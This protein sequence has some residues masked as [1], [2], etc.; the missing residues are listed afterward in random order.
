MG[1]LEFRGARLDVRLGCSDAERAR[2][3]AVD[4]DVAVRFAELPRACE[5]DDLSHTV[6]YADLIDAARAACAGREFKLVERLAH[7]LHARLRPLVPAGAALWLRVTKL[8]PP[9]E[10]LA[11]GVSFAL[12]DFEAADR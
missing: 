12:G 4:L 2:P 5:S 3:Q 9:V 7:E 10:G 6:C 11:G 8:H 1:V